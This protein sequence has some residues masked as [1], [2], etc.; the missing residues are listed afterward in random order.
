MSQ[1]RRSDLRADSDATVTDADN[2][3]KKSFQTV[4]RPPVTD[5]NIND[6]YLRH[7][8]NNQPLEP[9]T[10]RKPPGKKEG[11]YDLE[12]TQD[13]TGILGEEVTG[14]YKKEA[15]LEELVNEDTLHPNK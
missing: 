3:F 4:G 9:M 15:A 13:T 6:E 2:T 12:D 14:R 11:A 5:T 8:P 7:P 1:V 10:D